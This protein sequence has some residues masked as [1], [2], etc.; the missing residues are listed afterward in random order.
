MTP[1][2]TDTAQDPNEPYATRIDESTAAIEREDGRT[3]AYCEFG[4]PDGP[5]VLVFH[6][7][8][9]SRGFGLLFEEAAEAV[10]CRIISPDRP[11]YGRSDPQPD[12]TLLDW[13]DDVTA[14]ADHLDFDRFAVLGVSGGGPYAA[15]CAHSI[16]NRLSG[17]ALVS[18]L[19]PPAGPRGRGI[20]IVSWLARWMPW[21]AG[22]PIKRTLTRAATDPE[23]AIEARAKSKTEAEVAMHRSDAGRRLNAQT[24]EAGRQGHRHVVREIAI[25]GREWR[26]DLADIGGTVDIWHGALDKTVSI[27]A[28]EHLATSIPTARLTVHDDVGHLSLPVNYADEILSKLRPTVTSTAR[29][30]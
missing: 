5:P 11:G 28:A 25:I 15:A 24:A 8:I 4:D 18:S 6:G 12:R 13:P 21:M 17:A 26:F 10:G 3:L 22:I 20:R 7:G 19:G 14:I 16:P 30:A 1:R 9:G 2:G 27:D 29:H 23:V